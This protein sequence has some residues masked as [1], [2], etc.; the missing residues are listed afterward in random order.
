MS[1]PAGQVISYQ[2]FDG[3]VDIIPQAP[4]GMRVRMPRWVQMK[5][6]TIY[7][8][9]KVASVVQEGGYILLAH[10]PAKARVSVR[11]PLRELTENVA[12]RGQS[13][14]VRW[15]GD[16][17]VDVSPSLGREPTYQNRMKP[18]IH[19]SLSA[20]DFAVPDTYELQ[21]A[22]R[23]AAMSMLARMD[24]QRGGQGLALAW[25]A[26]T[27]WRDV[28]GGKEL[29]VHLLS[30]RAVNGPPEA[31]LTSGMPIAAQVWSWLPYEGR[32]A[33]VAHQPLARLALR[34]PDGADPNAVRVQRWFSSDKHSRQSPATLDGQY[35]IVSDV[36]AGERIDIAFALEEY[37]TIE[38]AADIRYR[39]QWKGSIVL[40]LEPKGSRVPLLCPS[41]LA[42]GK[43]DAPMPA[44]VSMTGPF[45]ALEPARVNLMP[46]L[47][48]VPPGMRQCR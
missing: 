1:G 11:Y 31:Q 15:R 18:V 24:L 44:A 12:A 38:T 2:P 5:D 28:P 29:R 20:S 7:V 27:E 19:Q 45:V 32:A 10:V 4:G 40:G 43:Q 16:L 33:V 48:V 21:D 8:G 25:N 17:V 37:E 47:L 9:D 34:L 35:V 14:Q 3:R 30:N 46:N 6:V 42:A 36:T 23:L 13:Y 39:V 26:Q 41:S 22:A